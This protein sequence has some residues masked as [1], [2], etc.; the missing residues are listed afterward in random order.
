MSSLLTIDIGNTRA[1]YAV[2]NND[3]IIETAVFNPY[4]NDLK[5]VISKYPLINKAILSSVGGKIQECL[6]Q[7]KNIEI[8]TLS[9][10][11]PLPF[12]IKYKNKRQIGS[13]RIVAVAAALA[14]KPDQNSLVIDIGTCITYD[15]ITADKIHLSGPISPGINLRFKSMNDY[16]E[17]LPL[18][19]PSN[20]E[21]KVICSSTEECLQAGVITAIT[22]EIEGFINLYS[23]IYNNLN[24]FIIGGDN[25]FFENKLKNCIFANANFTFNGLRYIL[26]YQ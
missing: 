21:L 4:S 18:C 11:T 25:I 2:F 5:D 3:N 20:D 10:E 24:V 9:G 19:T 15:I 12:E 26:D 8:I 7:L 17:K 23:N 14:E 6:D 16:T 1:K 13:D 22:L